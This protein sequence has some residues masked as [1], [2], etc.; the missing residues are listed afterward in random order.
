M[1]VELQTENPLQKHSP[2]Y[3]PFKKRDMIDIKGFSLYPYVSPREVRKILRQFIKKL[4]PDNYDV[5]MPVLKGGDW[6]ANKLKRDA[7]FRDKKFVPIEYHGNP[8]S[9][10]NKAVI[11]VPDEY[12]YSSRVLVVEGV[13]DTG[14]T[15]SYVHD[16]CPFAQSIAVARKLFSGQVLP[17]NVAWAIDIDDYWMCGCGTDIGETE[18]KHPQDFGRSYAGIAV[19]P[20]YVQ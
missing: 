1:S 20:K 9:N 5:I 14:N 7:R 11:R 4:D 10:G 8:H 16:D 3:I 18:D 15:L 12:K 17:P 2:V 6:F 13:I 19:Y